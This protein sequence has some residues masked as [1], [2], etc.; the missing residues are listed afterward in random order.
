M[1]TIVTHISPDADAIT[2]TWLI[3]RYLPGWEDAEHAFVP[4]GSTLEGKDPDENPNI[5]HV[6]TGLGKFDHHQFSEKL[7][8]T[9]VVFD[10]LKNEGCIKQRDLAPL[11]RMV[12]HITVVDNFGE[13]YYP[14]PNADVYEFTYD[15]IL[16]G[17]HAAMPKD[18]DLM[19]YALPLADAILQNF[20]NK[21]R[22]EAELKEGMVLHTS[23]GKTLV[24]ES[25][26]EELMKV[27]LKNGFVLVVR[28]DVDRG[29]IRI[30]TLPEK[31]YDL[32]PVHKM[33]IEK[34]PHAT[35]F[36]HK[37]GNMLL[38]GSSKNPNSVPSK[39]SMK[40]LIEIIKGM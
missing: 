7:S 2:S 8:A 15:Q 34:D 32:S 27:A 13:V 9:K 28:R 16:N 12:N 25:K 29:S 10:Y 4:A 20:K 22:A 30:K 40:Q 37:S 38:N 33:I 5:I 18:H 11:E 36:L 24:I 23:Y 1:K 39:L 14:D 21:V 31:K 6:D 3:K 17:L 26:N 35:W 19:A